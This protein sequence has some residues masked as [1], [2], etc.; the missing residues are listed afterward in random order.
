MQTIAINAAA[1]WTWIEFSDYQPHNL[2]RFFLARSKGAIL[3][4]RLTINNPKKKAHTKEGMDIIDTALGT[5]RRFWRGAK[6]NGLM[7]RA[8]SDSARRTEAVVPIV[9][10]VLPSEGEFISVIWKC[11]LLEMLKLAKGGLELE[12]WEGIAE[13]RRRTHQLTF[14][15]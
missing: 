15:D 4:T 7:N 1:L 10:K 9:V 14:I 2:T 13:M 8:S 11:P 12:D 3:K 5:P 6:P